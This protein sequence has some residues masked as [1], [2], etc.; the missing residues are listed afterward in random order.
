MK[1]THVRLH[2]LGSVLP[3]EVMS[4]AELEAL[5]EP[6][7]SRLKLPAGRLELMTGIRERRF[8]PA[9]TLPGEISVESCRNALAAG[10]IG[11]QQ[12]GCLIHGSVCRDALEP[13]TAAGVHHRLGLSPNCQVYDVSNACLGILNGMLQVACLIELGAI[14]AGLVVGS[15]NGRSLVETTVAALNRDPSV[16]RQSIKDQVASLTIGAASCAFLLTHRSLSPGGAALRGAAV[17]AHSEHYG[18]CRSDHDRA[19][20]DFQPLMN[21]DSHQLMVRGV[22]TGVATLPDFLVATGWLPEQIDRTVCHQVGVAHQKLML[23]ALGL[24]PARDHTTFP[25]L[26]NTG[27]AALP[28]TLADAARNSLLQPGHRVALLG[29]GSGINCVMAGLDWGTVPVQQTVWTA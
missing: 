7:Y 13:A 3:G 18:L 22:E 9:A 8:F 14:Q 24:D 12:I 11:P 10:Q 29:I 6:L 26:G 17:R 16:T 5:L 21:T 27:S 4:T 19:G 2:A 15:E 25:W 28:L 23:E 20:G 1:F